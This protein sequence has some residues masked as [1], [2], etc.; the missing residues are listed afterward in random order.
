MA[1]AWVKVTGRGSTVKGHAS[2]GGQAPN[3][4]KTSA[5]GRCRQPQEQV[6]ERHACSGGQ[7][8]RE[9]PRAAGTSLAQ[10]PNRADFNTHSVLIGAALPWRVRVG[11]LDL[12]PGV[13]LDPL[14]VEHLVALVARQRAP[15][16]SGDCAERAD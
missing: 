13:G 1:S 14:V 16:L 2:N 11:E 12:Q 5:P 3:Q 8:S 7:Y 15:Q 6:N 9:S 10:Q 4:A